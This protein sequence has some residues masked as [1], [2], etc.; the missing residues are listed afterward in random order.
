MSLSGD[1]L[2]DLRSAIRPRTHEKTALITAR[3][4]EA[5]LSPANV[6]CYEKLHLDDH[7]VRS[8]VLVAA[9]IKAKLSKY[10]V[11]IRPC[12]EEPLGCA[13]QGCVFKAGPGRVVKISSDAAEAQLFGWLRQ[14]RDLP[15][16]L[17]R[18]YGTWRT[19]PYKPTWATS[20]AA[21]EPWYAIWREDLRDLPS[22]QDGVVYEL[23]G[24][25]ENGA[26]TRNLV[27]AG[28]WITHLRK[29]QAIAAR[30]RR[31]DQTR[32]LRLAAD[33]L[34]WLLD[35]RLRISDLHETNW[36]WRGGAEDGT[37]VVRDLGIYEGDVPHKDVSQ[38]GGAWSRGWIVLRAR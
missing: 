37:L 5:I 35:R 29:M 34:Q 7:E 31:S 10:R 25:M 23:L 17:P 11:I 6:P 33:L 32:H 12:D 16:M 14:Q 13:S 26:A 15:L 36:G 24:I 38:L 22:E 1:A 2:D 8:E 3:R 20:R 28:K 21:G 30:A 9:A 18:C 19:A 27:D 4:A